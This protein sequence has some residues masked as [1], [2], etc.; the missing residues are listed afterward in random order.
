MKE[1]GFEKNVPWH[2]MGFMVAKAEKR[3]AEGKDTIFYRGGLQVDENKIEMFKRRRLMS[4]NDVSLQALP[5]E[6]CVPSPRFEYRRLRYADTPPHIDYST[7]KS[8]EDLGQSTVILAGQLPKD[9]SVEAQPESICSER[10]TAFMPEK[11]E[12]RV[13]LPL[14]KCFVN[15]LEAHHCPCEAVWRARRQRIQNVALEQLDKRMRLARY[16]RTI[17]PR[18]LVEIFYIN[19]IGKY[20]QAGGEDIAPE[21][22]IYLTE[23]LTYLDE[24]ASRDQPTSLKVWVKSEL[25]RVA[26]FARSHIYST[27]IGGKVRLTFAG[28][29]L[30]EVN[31]AP[32]AE[33]WVPEETELSAFRNSEV[34]LAP[35][36][37]SHMIRGLVEHS[38]YLRLLKDWAALLSVIHCT[39][40]ALELL[41]PAISK[42]FCSGQIL[43]VKSILLSI[44][45]PLGQHITLGKVEEILHLNNKLL[46]IVTVAPRNMRGHQCLGWVEE[47]EVGLEGDASA[48]E[49]EISSDEEEEIALGD[50]ENIVG[51]F[52]SS[53]ESKS[54]NKYGE[55][56]TE[57]ADT[58]SRIMGISFDYSSLFG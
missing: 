2:D 22:M 15:L 21:L 47:G 13:S 7:P 34:T 18:Y 42:E 32:Y 49:E 4:F 12:T 5:S 40:Q 58:E 37:H 44:P 30:L 35:L 28:A 9:V 17:Q 26:R 29:E 24:S 39:Y 14:Q 6:C 19:T 53:I 31:L 52:E 45:R 27:E 41:G 11:G 3:K 23:I 36:I 8:V 57:S 10:I 16:L 50:N 25:F 56:Y 51:E 55:T 20:I 48:S 38:L 33:S 54:S 46:E 1:W 43:L